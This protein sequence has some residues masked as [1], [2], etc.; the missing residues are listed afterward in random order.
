MSRTNWIDPDGQTLRKAQPGERTCADCSSSRPGHC[1]YGVEV[2]PG[3]PKCYSGRCA[4]FCPTDKY[5][6]A[7]WRAHK[8]PEE[9]G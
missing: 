9:T 3:S 8:S 1:Q 7:F 5:L 4:K 6:L 2:F